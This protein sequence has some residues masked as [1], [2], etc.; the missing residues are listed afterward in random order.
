LKIG[1]LFGCKLRIHWSFAAQLIITWFI[2][3]HQT[4][5]PGG[6]LRSS[7][8]VLLQFVCIFLH[9]LG[10]LFA[11]RGF[12]IKTL[13]TTLYCMGGVARLSRVPTN[14]AQQ[15]VIAM[16]G[17]FASSLI[18]IF[19]FILAKTAYGPNSLVLVRD[20]PLLMSIAGANML[21]MFHNLAPAF[22]FDGGRLLQMILGTRIPTTRAIEIPAWAGQVFGVL[23]A[24]ITFIS[25]PALLM[26]AFGM[27]CGARQQAA[28]EKLSLLREAK[29]KS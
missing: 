17:P 12:K 15:L 5:S 26:N 16:A 28:I 25:S 1:S 21:L 18:G 19:F 13:E 3:F 11:A 14:Q 10:H 29:A 22:P 6:V 20:I 23:F 2:Y 4:P 24:V 9:E 27:V 8:L 7:L